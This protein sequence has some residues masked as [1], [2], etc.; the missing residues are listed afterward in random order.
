[1][2]PYKSLIGTT[3]HVI[4][5]STSSKNSLTPFILCVHG[6]ISSHSNLPGNI[7]LFLIVQK[8]CIKLSCNLFFYLEVIQKYYRCERLKNTSYKR[9]HYQ[10][11][12]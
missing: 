5:G 3:L 9:N 12:C 10:K 8:Y 7:Y 11:A 2:G 4:D 1:M 6:C